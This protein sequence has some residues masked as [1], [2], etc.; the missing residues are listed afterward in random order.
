MRAVITTSGF[1]WFAWSSLVKWL[2]PDY[3]AVLFSHNQ[4]GGNV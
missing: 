3:T 2:I 1:A 4:A